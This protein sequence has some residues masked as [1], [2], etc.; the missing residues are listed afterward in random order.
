[1]TVI[2]LL[3]QQIK[4]ISTDPHHMSEG[5]GTSSGLNTN[6]NSMYRIMESNS[7]WYSC[8]FSCTK[9]AYS[10]CDRLVTSGNLA[11]RQRW[12]LV[13]PRNVWLRKHRR[14]MG[15]PQKDTG[16][17]KKHV[18][19]GFLVE[20]LSRCCLRWSKTSKYRFVSSGFPKITTRGDL[21]LWFPTS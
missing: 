18:M 12:L 5:S 20:T 19:L 7:Q 13:S 17:P 11:L 1:M 16:Q 3:Q 2:K 4:W 9:L 21:K 14:A 15:R 10:C 8:I 6:S